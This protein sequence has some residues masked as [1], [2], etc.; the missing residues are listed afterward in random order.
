MLWGVPEPDPS[1]TPRLERL[2]RAFDT[3]LE[4]GLAGRPRA[5][6]SH[7]HTALATRGADTSGWPP[8][9]RVAHAVTVAR[10]LVHVDGGAGS[11]EAARVAEQQLLGASDRLDPAFL[12]MC[13]SVLPEPYLLTGHARKASD[14][15][16]IAWDHAVTAGEPALRLRCHAAM[17]ASLAL[18]GELSAARQRCQIAID[19]GPLPSDTL[20]WTLTLAQVLSGVQASRVRRAADDAETPNG[21]MPFMYDAIGQLARIQLAATAGKPWET[22]AAAERVTSGVH[23]IRYPRLVLALAGTYSGYAFL[24]LRQ[25]A[26]AVR[27][28]REW[29]EVPEHTV[30]AAPVRAIAELQL[31]RPEEALAAT[32]ECVETVPRHNL[33]PLPTVRLARA[34]AMDRLGE[35]AQAD[36][37]FALGAHLAVSLG[38]PIIAAGI[39]PRALDRLLG[40]LADAQPEIARRAASHLLWPDRRAEEPRTQ[41]PPPHL[42]RREEVIAEWLTTDLTFAQIADRLYISVNTVKTQATSVYR[43][44]GVTSRADAVRGLRLLGLAGGSGGPP[45]ADGGDRP[46]DP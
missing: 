40:R 3:I 22:L 34:V 8:R 45:R 27:A 6:T 26:R 23:S 5:T 7:I 25:P 10:S 46:D 37:E 31:D 24:I 13:W 36:A 1:T 4:S 33:R 43:K 12:A 19:E 17:A 35:P 20:P 41:P 18:N 16:G 39:P 11:L 32:R 30:C 9:L 29:V 38:A 15:S 28:V 44:L 42:T 14:L 21:D 2:D